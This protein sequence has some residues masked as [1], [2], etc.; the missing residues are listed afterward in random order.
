VPDKPPIAF[1][2]FAVITV[3]EGTMTPPDLA[4]ALEE[5]LPAGKHIF[6][7]KRKWRLT[8]HTTVDGW[9]SGRL[10]FDSQVSAGL[11]NEPRKDYDRI[12]PSQITPWVIETTTGRVA[13]ELKAGSIKPESFRGTF[14]A[15]LNE[16]ATIFRWRVSLEEQS[17][18]SWEEWTESVSRITNLRVKMTVPNPRYRGELVEHLFDDA[19][20]SAATL[21]VQGDDIDLDD[22]EL[23]VQSI[24]HAQRGY[25]RIRAKGVSGPDAERR[26]WR[27]E[28]HG[29]PAR[30]EAP[31]DPETMEVPA[32][33]LRKLLERWPRK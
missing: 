29:A 13:F 32:G 16:G 8:E 10:G 21:A 9:M 11:W 25:G 6:R 30:E 14:Q 17:Y 5:A 26:E 20:L 1:V 23:L 31:R 24:E 33:S 4:A 15:L 12:H 2:A 18:P 7:H 22:S 27:S 28:E 3:E 19:K